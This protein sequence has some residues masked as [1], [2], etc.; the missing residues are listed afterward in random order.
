MCE[1]VLP[2]AEGYAQ[3][4]VSSSRQLP[5]R[6]KMWMWPAESETASR[7]PSGSYSK[8]V[9]LRRVVR[10][11]RSRSTLG[12]ASD[13][14][15]IEEELNS[16]VRTETGREGPSSKWLPKQQSNLAELPKVPSLM[17]KDSRTGNGWLGGT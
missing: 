7:V 1:S 11:R 9:C 4:Q 12:P 14:I 8:S 10:Y 13:I 5:F 6:P 16:T 17:N 15:M 2:S 3:K